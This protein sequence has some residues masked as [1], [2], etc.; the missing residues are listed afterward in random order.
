MTNYNKLINT[1]IIISAVDNNNIESTAHTWTVDNV[2]RIEKGSMLSL[3]FSDLGGVHEIRHQG[4]NACGTSCTTE[5][6]HTIT[7]VDKLPSDSSDTTK[8]LMYTA[9]L[10]AVGFM[11]L[12]GKTDSKK[13][14]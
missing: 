8:L 14:K 13:K 9:A 12:K 7:M 3:T 11:F 6:I 2:T 4:T 10:G 1:P 5:T